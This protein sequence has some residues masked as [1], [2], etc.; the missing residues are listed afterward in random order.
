MEDKKSGTA[1]DF[2]ALI[3][4]IRQRSDLVEIVSGYVSL[5]PSGR[6]LKG[7]C[8]FHSESTPSFHVSREKGL[9]HCYG[10][11]AGGDVF[12]FVEKIDTLSFM[13]AA[14]RLARRA[15]VPFEWANQGKGPSSDARERYRRVNEM[16]GE[17]YRESL[18]RDR[19]ALDYL[20][21][22]GITPSTVE[23]FQ[24]GYAPE[25][26]EGLTTALVS[27]GVQPKELIDVGLSLEGRSGGAYDRFRQRLMFPIWDSE[28][29]I[30]AFGGRA[31]GDFQPKYLNT[32]ESALFVKSRTLY[33]LHLARKA[34]AEADSCVIVEGYVDVLACH[35]WG[36]RNVVATMGTAVS[37]GHLNVLSRLTRKV[38]I[39]FDSDSAGMNATLRSIPL[40]EEAG[41][42]VRVI[43]LPK[44]EDPDEF[45]R[46]R[47]ADAFKGVI[48]EARPVVEHRL[49]Q[50]AARHD[51]TQQDHRD[52]FLKEAVQILSE[53]RDPTDR[54]TYAARIAEKCFHPNTRMVQ[55]MEEAIRAELTRRVHGLARTDAGG[56]RAPETPS[57][58]PPR[59]SS[60][61]KAEQGLLRALLNDSGDRERV[62]LELGPADFSE[63]THRAIAERAYALHAEGEPI[64]AAS[65]IQGLGDADAESLASKL[66]LEGEESTPATEYIEAV[67]WESLRRR[68]RELRAA[69]A[70]GALSPEE[71][72]EY[73][74]LVTLVHTKRY[75]KT[76]IG[77]V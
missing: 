24:L 41:F 1:R 30:I 59:E 44:G 23:A 56:R 53:V 67:K 29:R 32:S 51:L 13:E 7:L 37:T 27:R 17:F 69:M 58:A 3:D 62:L 38:A 52:A 54:Q 46:E 35:Q 31:M 70:K 57:A 55:W 11:G 61:I 76:S 73:S 21:H 28:G 77:G 65:V 19:S 68:E 36:F 14:E 8:P 15:G 66:L 20:K 39:A 43:S 2:R 42:T 60:L 5:K 10:C 45:L 26:W 47:G 9:F 33:A 40:F 50:A 63:P 49:T 16:A 74:R 12:K 6:N 22:R 75:G 71:E 4:E 34:I 72:T 18:Q 48:A 25:G 64:D